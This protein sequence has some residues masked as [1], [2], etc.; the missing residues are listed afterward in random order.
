MLLLL[1]IGLNPYIIRYREKL[2]LSVS[3][4]IH[5]IKGC[6]FT[7]PPFEARSFLRIKKSVRKKKKIEETKEKFI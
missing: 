5:N 4:Y 3:V 6:C 2:T 7:R 1:L